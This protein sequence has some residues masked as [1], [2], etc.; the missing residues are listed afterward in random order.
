MSLALLRLKVQLLRISQPLMWPEHRNRKRKEQDN[1]DQ[2]NRRIYANERVAPRDPLCPAK[3]RNR[4]SREKHRICRNKVVVLRMKRHHHRKK[5][6]IEDAQET[7]A[8]RLFAKQQP[9]H[10]RCPQKNV[11][12]SQCH[13]L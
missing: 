11:R 2:Q 7:I 3:N 10:S 1:A 12:W 4:S 6:K 13:N 5:D 8:S 9:K